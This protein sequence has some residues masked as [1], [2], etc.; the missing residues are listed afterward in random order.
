MRWQTNNSSPGISRLLILLCIFATLAG[1]ARRP[2]TER[3]EGDRYDEAS[4]LMDSLA[5]QNET[6][7]KTLEG[8]LALVYTNALEKKALAGYLEFSMPT[9]YRFVVT[10]PFGQPVF[11][12][13]GDHVAFQAIHVP[14]RKYMAGSMRSFGLRY[15]LPGEILSKSWGEWIMAR[16]TR[17]SQ[18][19]TAIHEDRQGRG[20]WI[21]FRHETGEPVGQSHL[22]VDPATEIILAR[23]LE[24]G[25]GNKIAE[26]T[27]EGWQG[28][29][30]CRQ[31][32]AVNITGL[33]YGTDIRLKFSEVQITDE[34]K[35]FQL[36]A[37]PGYLK[38][39]MP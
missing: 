27:Y 6:C 28:Q 12:V 37:P 34:K 15:N 25:E 10:N 35:R 5:A 31:P 29:E 24:S 38:Q 33:D 18:T 8:D 14:D 13:A 17:S 19:I 2:W 23:I 30:K 16:N 22:L 36:S 11:V 9:A 32:H 39:F 26:V 7:G 4:R 20:I 3:L 1:C 21:T